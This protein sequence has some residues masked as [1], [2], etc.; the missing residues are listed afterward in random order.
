MATKETIIYVTRE[1][2]RALGMA[3]N[4]HYRIVTNRT[5]YG[6]SIQKQYPDFVTLIT[7]PENPGQES[8]GT[9]DLMRHPETE[10]LVADLTQKTG[11]RPYILVF[12]NT[13]RIEP[14]ARERGWLLI[15]PP[16]ATS[17]KIENKVSQVTWLGEL[18]PRLPS[19]GLS[20]TKSIVWRGTPFVIQWAHGHTGTGT[21]LIDDETKL[22]SLKERFPDRRCRVT[23]FVK[24]PSFTVNAIVTP[25]QTAISSVS[26]QITGLAPFT[27]SRFATIGNDW[28]VAKTL[29][30]P[31]DLAD[32]KKLAED[33]GEKMRREFWRGLF[34]IDLI[35]DAATGK[36]YLIEV[37]ARQPAS[38]TFESNLQERQR[39]EG[40]SQGLTTLEAHI[41]ALLGQPLR[42]QLI[43][44]IDG[45]QIVQR[46]TPT[47]K[48]VRE[49]AIGSLELAGYQT[50]SY[51]NTAEN[52]DLL[53]VQSL[54]G[55]MKGHDELNDKGKEIAETLKQ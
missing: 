8:L 38:T 47:V 32:I 31:S 39:A 48:S 4:E 22:V 10:K 15:N 18:E 34:G 41:S 12:K 14:L 54:D 36:L 27:A 43:Q 35:K 42:Q 23:D 53:R 1:I 3:P 5:T 17:E 7:D 52:E 26:Y 9:G 55:I 19:H 11:A 37:N 49:D 51:P 45:A 25:E 33:L 20:F 40:H 16:A 28:S 46:V 44:I 6:E 30:S 50:I 13:A 29:L 21:I 2:E 24:G